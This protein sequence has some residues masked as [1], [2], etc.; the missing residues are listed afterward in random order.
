M[1]LRQHQVVPRAYAVVPGHADAEPIVIH[2]NHTSMV[3]YPSR[4]DTGYVAVPEHLLVMASGAT[5][6]VQ[7]RWARER[8]ADDGRAA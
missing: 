1:I 6:G 4:Q 7:Q 2:A 5:D 8:R 3:R